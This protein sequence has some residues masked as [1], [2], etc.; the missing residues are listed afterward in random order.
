MGNAEVVAE[1]AEIVRVQVA[2]LLAGNDP[3]RPFMGAVSCQNDPM[4]ERGFD[5]PRD[6]AARLAEQA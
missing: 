3:N 6:Q 2:R 4:V 5:P 1:E